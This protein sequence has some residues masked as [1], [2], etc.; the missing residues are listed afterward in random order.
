MTSGRHE[1]V[2][3]RGPVAVPTAVEFHRPPAS[4]LNRAQDPAVAG[5][6]NAVMRSFVSQALFA[7]HTG[8]RP[9]QMQLREAPLPARCNSPPMDLVR[10]SKV[11]GTDIIRR[12]AK[13]K[14]LGKTVDRGMLM[15]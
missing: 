1:C 7:C 9:P 3:H 12:D 15:L 10:L 14:P 5:Y 11:A 6:S 13:A 2:I 4:G 8:N